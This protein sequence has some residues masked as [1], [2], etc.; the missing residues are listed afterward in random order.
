MIN[1]KSHHVHVQIPL[2]RYWSLILNGNLTSANNEE[3][4]YARAE[5]EKGDINFYIVPFNP[6]RLN[7][8]AKLSIIS[9]VNVISSKQFT[10][11]GTPLL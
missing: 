8:L 9:P 10:E 3:K 6:D 2:N 1:N 5:E 7:F 11:V 4:L